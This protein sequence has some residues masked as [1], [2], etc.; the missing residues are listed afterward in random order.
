MKNLLIATLLLVSYTS[1]CQTGYFPIVTPLN[2]WVV[3]YTHPLG[4]PSEKI[5][6][7]TFAADSTLLEGRYY[8]ELIFSIDMSGGPWVSSG[9]F[10]REENGKV[11]TKYENQTEKLIYDFNF[12]IGDSLTGWINVNQATRYVTQ[13]GSTQLLDGVARKKIT[14]DSWCGET[15]WIEG[16]GETF[17]LFNSE[18]VCSLWDGVLLYIRCF[19]TNGQLLYQ[20]PDVSGC[21]TS[22]VTDVE[23]GAIKV[24][25]N[26][27][28]GILY[29]ETEN[30]AEIQSI[31]IFNSLG[32]LVLNT[33]H[34][35][36]FNKSIDI[37]ALTSG[38][39]T[40]LVH[41]KNGGAKIFKLANAD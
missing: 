31:Q 3:D 23:M 2:E 28:S 35:L 19:S 24:Y 16:I 7:Y 10:L 34:L 41:F 26:P 25:P 13:V 21:Y 12:G 30:E 38:F 20:R 4:W 37:T 40:G 6:R 17:A 5:R 9:S 1:F 33:N 15:E 11:Y 29:F 18:T 36:P 14:L 39:Y 8:Q 32:V 22:A 27:A